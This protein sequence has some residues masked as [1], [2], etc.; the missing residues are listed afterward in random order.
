MLPTSEPYVEQAAMA[1]MDRPNACSGG[2][3]FRQPHFAT[4]NCSPN[5]SSRCNNAWSLPDRTAVQ[6]MPHTDHGSCTRCLQPMSRRRPKALDRYASAFQVYRPGKI[7]SRKTS[8]REVLLVVP[9]RA[10]TRPDSGDGTLAAGRL[11]LA[12][13]SRNWRATAE[14]RGFCVRLVR[15]LRMPQLPRQSCVVRELPGQ[16]PRGARYA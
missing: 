2:V 14:P 15:D 16:S 7:P 3:F 8:R 10:R 5:F 13:P 4:K 1:D 6:R 11:L 12:L 9:S